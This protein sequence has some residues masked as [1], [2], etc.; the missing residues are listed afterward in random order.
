LT[1]APRSYA[2][3]LDAGG[4]VP[5]VEA[6]FDAVLCTDTMCHLPNRLDILREWHRITSPGARVLFTDPT[7][8]TGLVTD[9]E[10]AAP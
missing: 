9:A 1:T 4:R 6:S 7:I 2:L 10:V 5:F 8:V 3:G